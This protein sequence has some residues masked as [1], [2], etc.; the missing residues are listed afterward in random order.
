MPPTE[1]FL[2]ADPALRAPIGERFADW[3]EMTWPG[4]AA[5]LARF[6][7]ALLAARSDDTATALLTEAP[8]PFG[9]CRA[10]GFVVLLASGDPVALAEAVEQGAFTA[11]VV[12]GRIAIDADSIPCGLIVGRNAQGEL[13]LVAIDAATARALQR[14]DIAALP[15]SERRSLEELGVLVPDRWP[16]DG[17]P[18]SGASSNA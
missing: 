15:D 8:N 11:R 16:L 9:L 18:V 2:A 5:E 3:L 1:A 17:V 14:E 13:L 10:R 7:A 12:D 6:E 4:P